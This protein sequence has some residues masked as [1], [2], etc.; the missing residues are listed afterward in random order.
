MAQKRRGRPPGKRKKPEPVIAARIPEDLLKSLEDLAKEHGQTHSA[1]TLSAEVNRA[2]QFW[3]K[4]HADPHRYNSALGIAI[5]VLA[6]EVEKITDKSWVDHPLTRQLVR[7]HVQEL[8]SHTLAPLSEPVA[9]PADI[10]EE[11][12]LILASLKHV[13]SRRGSRLFTGTVI[14]DDPALAM[15]SQLLSRDLGDG[16]TNVETRPA[17][18]ARRMQDEKAWVD[19]VRAGSAEAF[20]DYV[21][22]F[23]FGRHVTHAR[24]RLAALEKQKGRK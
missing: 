14:T 8:V 1:Q 20:T 7:E 18:V 12:G 5:T 21:Q 24:E 4:R 22:R 15:I 17:L 6:D 10:R 13:I 19:A 3:V 9:V 16:R 23:R 11:A 2:L